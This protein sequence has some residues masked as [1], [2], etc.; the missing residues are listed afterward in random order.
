MSPEETV[1]LVANRLGVAQDDLPKPLAEL[2]RQRAGGNPF[3]AEELVFAL[4]DQG[5]LHVEEED[6]HAF[7]VLSE[8]FDHAAAALPDDVQGL[9]LSRIDKLETE[10]QLT[11]KVASVIG[12]TFPYRTLR[13]VLAR[14]ASIDDTMLRGHLATLEKLDLTPLETPE[15]ELTYIFRHATTQ[16]VAYG[17]LLFAQRREL[18]HT[19]AGWY[20]ETFESEAELAPYFPLLVHHYH[21]A[22]DVGRERRYAGLAGHRAAAQYANDD[23][24]RY[25]SRALELT[26]EA[27]LEER[28][29]LLLSREKVL[30]LLGAR[31]EQRQDLAVL[32]DIVEASEDNHRQAN[33]VLRQANYAEVMADYPQAIVAAR[34]VIALA[35]QAEDVHTEALGHLRWGGILRLQGE[36]EAARAKLEQSKTLARVGRAPQIEADSLRVLG[37]VS[38]LLG[39]YADAVD[40]LEQSLN[41]Y[42]KVGDRIGEGKAYDTL[43]SILTEQGNYNSAERYLKEALHIYRE[44]GYQR[45]ESTALINL[46]FVQMEQGDYVCVKASFEQSLAISSEIEDQQSQGWAHNNLGLVYLSLGEY[47]KAHTHFDRALR[48]HRELGDQRDEGSTLSNLGLLF[49]CR[50]E[51]EAGREFSQ[52]ALKIAQR[53]SDRSTEAE[54]LINLGHALRGLGQL[55]SAAKAYQRGLV[56]RRELGEEN[57]TMETLA[58]LARVSL[59]QGDIAQAQAHT[60]EILTYLETGTLEGT[61]E[62]FR[63]YLTCYRVL[64]AGGD[65]RAGE[66]LAT[67]YDLLQERASKIEDEAMQRSFLENVDAHRKIIEAWRN[68]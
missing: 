55:D 26:S 24:V 46:G 32:M 64:E 8:D 18:H 2:V 15:P 17:T 3:F 43:G 13:H 25:L 31:E 44:I 42:R 47:A 14:H 66:V 40:S 58:G 19:V 28:Y 22:E 41:I 34:E 11:L 12:R 37:I 23:A 5:L 63:V 36:Y 60:E 53:V 29:E 6:G 68:R 45:G 49:C 38:F 21:H 16:E 67:A 35:T 51:N 20:E 9:V 52:Q 10:Q 62:P 59:A 33:V 65:A 1:A 7:C 56:I 61:Y 54:S 39:D 4:R 50:G 48:I 27:A 57:M 30:D